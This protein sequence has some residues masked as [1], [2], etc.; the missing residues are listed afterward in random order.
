[1]PIRPFFVYCIY[2][3]GARMDFDS[4]VLDTNCNCLGIVSR[5]VIA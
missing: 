2:Q 1:M 4:K 3:R 5:R